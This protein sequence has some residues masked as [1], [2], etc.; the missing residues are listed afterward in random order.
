MIVAINLVLMVFN[1]SMGLINISHGAKPYVIAT[2]FFAAGFSAMATI[3]VA[4]R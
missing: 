4:L 1:L 2:N 3:A